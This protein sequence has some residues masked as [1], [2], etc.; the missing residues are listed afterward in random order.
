MVKRMLAVAAVATGL[1]CIAR[2][3]GDGY[4]TVPDPL[5][6][7]SPGDLWPLTLNE[8]SE[9]QPRRCAM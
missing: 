9:E 3:V 7:D 6:T 2:D 1:N 8:H 4:G 5:R